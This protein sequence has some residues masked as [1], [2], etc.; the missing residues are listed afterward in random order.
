MTPPVAGAQALAMAVL[1][2]IGE[3]SGIRTARTGR[4]GIIAGT[5]GEEVGRESG[6]GAARTGQ[7]GIIAGSA[8]KK[9]GETAGSDFAGFT[10]GLGT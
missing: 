8:G 3:E 4:V 2:K 7:V 9:V 10:A 1:V 6:I 5:A